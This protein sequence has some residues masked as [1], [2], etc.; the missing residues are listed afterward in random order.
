[1]ESQRR[2]LKIDFLFYLDSFREYI[3]RK[4]V[5][6][7]KQRLLYVY[8]ILGENEYPIYVGKTNDLEVRFRAHQETKPNM[9]NEHTKILVNEF[10]NE[11]DQS[12][13]E[14]LMIMKYSPKYNSIDNFHSTFEIPDPK[15]DTWKMYDEMLLKNGCIST[16]NSSIKVSKRKINTDR[17]FYDTLWIR[18]EGEYINI[19]GNGTVKLDEYEFRSLIKEMKIL[20]DDE[21]HIKSNLTKTKCSGIEA[22]EKLKKKRIS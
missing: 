5:V 21:I 8:K 6:L 19:S 2:C 1:M 11:N 3:N 12:A 14:K 9:W 18:K 4:E 13:Y 16:N 10:D 17:K 22:L 15:K 7:I 20:L